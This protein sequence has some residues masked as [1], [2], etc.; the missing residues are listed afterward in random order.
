M[1]TQSKQNEDTIQYLLYRHLIQVWV[2]DVEISWMHVFDLLE[3]ADPKMDFNAKHRSCE[4][5]TRCDARNICL[6]LV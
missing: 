1:E 5:E 2:F 4:P 6:N 3:L